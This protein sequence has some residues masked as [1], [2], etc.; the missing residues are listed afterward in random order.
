MQCK[1]LQERI[2]LLTY[3]Y[4]FMTASGFLKNAENSSD[5]NI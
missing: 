5:L 1:D 2:K 4:P 3:K